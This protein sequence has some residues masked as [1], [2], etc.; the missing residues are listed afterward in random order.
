MIAACPGCG[1]RRKRGGLCPRCKPEHK[2]RRSRKSY[3]EQGDEILKRLRERR[4][5]Q[6]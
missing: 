3:K 4:A 2:L 6:F 5:T 1:R